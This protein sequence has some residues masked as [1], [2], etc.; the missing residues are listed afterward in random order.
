M[1]VARKYGCTI[2]TDP[3][4]VQ[5]RQQTVAKDSFA[6]R[7]CRTR[8]TLRLG[9][10]TSEYLSPRLEMCLGPA[11]FIPGDHPVRFIQRLVSHGPDGGVRQP[12]PPCLWRENQVPRRRRAGRSTQSCPHATSLSDQ[13]DLS[14]AAQ[15]DGAISQSMG[16]KRA[17]VATLQPRR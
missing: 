7:F 1:S 6:K 4:Q 9:A 16:R 5:S 13:Y 8:S 10:K 15:H 17:W 2:C 3:R 12:P 11:R 14:A